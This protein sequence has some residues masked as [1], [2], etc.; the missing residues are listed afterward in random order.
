[1]EK[2]K[3]N[4]NNRLLLRYAGLGTQ[5]L[6]AIGLGV[7]G[8]LK[9]DEYLAFKTPLFVW[10]LPLLIIAVTIYKIVKD[11]SSKK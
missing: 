9:L 5:L 4:S 3:R 8:G 1:M 7:Y 11:T 10:L 6:V 2:E